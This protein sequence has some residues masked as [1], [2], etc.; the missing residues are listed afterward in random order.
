MADDEKW[1]ELC[2]R[3]VAEEDPEKLMELV[4]EIERVFEQIEEEKKR[5]SPKS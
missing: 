2:A 4:T 3:A 5:S 1:K